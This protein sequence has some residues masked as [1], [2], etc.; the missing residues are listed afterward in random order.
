MGKRKGQ[1]YRPSYS[2]EETPIRL[3][4]GEAKPSTNNSLQWFAHHLGSR[5]DM[6]TPDVLLGLEGF[7]DIL[8]HSEISPLGWNRSHDSLALIEH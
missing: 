3:I 4:D 5:E 8:Y 7:W 1:G 6:G 2:E